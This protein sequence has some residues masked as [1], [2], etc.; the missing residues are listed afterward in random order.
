MNTTTIAV[1]L[2]KSVFELA[3][4]GGQGRAT[5]RKRLSREAFGKF[6]VN[7]EPCRVAMEACGTAH[8]WARTF[9]ALGH[10]VKLL[11]PQHVR[12]Y[13]RRNKAGR[14]DAAALPGPTAAAASCRCRSSPRTSRPCKGCTASAAAGWR[15]GR[16]GSTRCAAFR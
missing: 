1:D 16:R 6:F 5:E 7:R 12:P 14:A 13:A 3:I 8:Y 15:R 11:P 4:S 2:A 9:R 10:E